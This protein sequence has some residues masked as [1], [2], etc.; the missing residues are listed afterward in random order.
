MCGRYEL[1]ANFDQ[2]PSPLKK[3]LPQRFKEH[4]KKQPLIR[5]SDPVLALKNQGNTTTSIMLWGFIPQWS[6]NPLDGPRPFNA[7]AETVDEKKLFRG[8]WRHQRCLLPA[9]GFLEKGHRI[10]QED[11]QPFWLGG[12]WNNWTGADGSEIESCCILT[13]QSNKLIQPFHNRMPVVIPN[14]L[15]EEWIASF[16]DQSELNALQEFLVGW[17][18]KGWLVEQIKN[19]PNLQLSLI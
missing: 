13:T 16:K 1:K 17:N 3:F 18:P 12:I 6:K 11:S 7:R 2:L 10:R 9:T 19:H 4:Y 15:E 14:G 5:P 8:S